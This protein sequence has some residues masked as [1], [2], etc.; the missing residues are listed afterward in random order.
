[1]TDLDVVQRF[2][3][4]FSWKVAETKG[5][6]KRAWATRT[7]KRDEIIYALDKMLPY[8]GNRRAYKA[9]NLLDELEL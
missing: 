2:A 4:I 1:M 8:F 7:G 6:V 5:T 3:S 9:L